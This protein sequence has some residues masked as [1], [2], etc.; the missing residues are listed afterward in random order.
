MNIWVPR[1]QSLLRIIAALNF[2][3]H[4]TQKLL[5]FPVDAPREAA[6]FPAQFWFAGLIESVGGVLLLLGLFTRPVAFIAAGEMAVAYFTSHFPGGFWPILNRGE[7]AVLYCF[8]WLYICVA[9][10]GPWSLDAWLAARRTL[11]D[12]AALRRTFANESLRTMGLDG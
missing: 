10:P 5:V 3:T 8:V 6:Q 12:S 2:M 7:L 11:L 4:G 9:G 1:F